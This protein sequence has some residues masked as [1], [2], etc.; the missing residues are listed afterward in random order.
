MFVRVLVLKE[1]SVPLRR[2]GLICMGRSWWELGSTRSIAPV[3]WE[4]DGDNPVCMGLGCSAPT[5]TRV[6]TDIS[7]LATVL[8][9]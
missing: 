5:L 1:G 8:Q 9:G 2:G 3:R 7:L 4:W 6:H